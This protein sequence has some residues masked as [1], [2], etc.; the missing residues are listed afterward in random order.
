MAKPKLGT[1]RPKATRTFIQRFEGKNSTTLPDGSISIENYV[2]DPRSLAGAQVVSQSTQTLPLGQVRSESFEHYYAG[3][4]A[5]EPES[6]TNYAL[7]SSVNGRSSN[8]QF[9]KALSTWTSA[10]PASR[11]SQSVLTPK[12]Q[13]SSTTPHTGLIVPAALAYDVLGR[14]T[15][16]VQGNLSASFSYDSLDRVTS[17]QNAAG[18]VSQYEY[19]AASR[20]TAMVSPEG[21]RALFTYDPHSADLI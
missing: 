17:A 16:S 5:G 19:D 14:L 6:F 2:G 11:N 21:K 15:N 10:S 3:S 9:D 20:V 4:V 8:V 18:E 13:V 12:G 7:R 1:V